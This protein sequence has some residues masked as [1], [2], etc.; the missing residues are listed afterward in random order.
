MAVRALKKAD[1]LALKKADGGALK[2]A[3]G[4]ALKK[5]N[6]TSRPS[7]PRKC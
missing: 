6:F 4:G 7:H 5:A 3:D 1:C 2:K